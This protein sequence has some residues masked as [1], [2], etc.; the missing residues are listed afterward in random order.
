MD[1]KKFLPGK[2]EKDDLEYYWVLIIEPGWVNAGIWRIKEGGAQV[3]FTGHQFSWGLD[4]ELINATDS[5]LSSAVQ[6]F[7][8][9]LKEPEKTVFAVNSS[10]VSGGQIKEEYLEKIKRLCSDL[11]LKPV[12]F[13]ILPEAIAHYLKSEED[14]SLNAILLG[15]Y[16]ESLEVTLFNLGKLVGTTI[17]AR[18]VSIADDVTEG[19]VRFSETKSLPS[20]FIV[21]DGREKEL[22]EVRQL[23]IS[24]NWDEFTK[25]KFFHTPKVEIIDASIKISAVSLAGAAEIAGVKTLDKSGKVRVKEEKRETDDVVKEEMAEKL[26]FAV[27]ESN[28]GKEVKE[29]ERKEV[30]SAAQEGWPV[31]NIGAVG[32]GKEKK[33]LPL[34]ILFPTLVEKCK[35]L[36]V[37]LSKFRLG[38]QSVSM[39]RKVFIFGLGFLLIFLTLGFVLWW[40][41]PKASVTIYISPKTLEERLSLTLDPD[42][43]ASDISARVLKTKVL[44]TKISSEKTKATTGTKTV[45]EK[46]KGE[47]SVYRVGSE[48]KIA[49]GTLIHGPENLK[50]VLDEELNLASGSAGS[51]SVSKGKVTAQDIGS[52]YNLAT[53]G[54]FKV[55]DYSLADLEAKNEFSFSGGSSREI[56]AV[57]RE[58]Q[59]DLEKDLEEEILAKAKEELRQKLEGSELLVE[60]SLSATASYQL[61]SHKVGD[62]SESLKLSL[63]LDTSTFSVVKEELVNLSEN[64]LK[65][66]IPEGFVL[67]SEQVEFELEREDEESLSFETLVR[68]NLL[69]KVDIEGIA[70]KIRGKYPSLAREYLIKEIPGVVRVEI[71]M[72][73][74]LPGRLNTLPRIAKNIEVE[75]AAEK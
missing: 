67:R 55:G 16:Q 74:S 64:I 19:L 39:G 3:V 62:E 27:G 57:S 65:E 70:K 47:A 13:V 5:A 63:I 49:S 43:S 75:I 23:L 41:Y 42:I 18:S 35:E 32:V 34:N 10:W 61:F 66:K 22:E 17:V 14:V 37:F 9:D 69:P 7:P 15:I 59:E 31:E 56:S 44:E 50:F 71:R 36:L 60:D 53:G 1:I 12:G 20:R 4:E 25:I 54:S 26:G 68:A 72:K 45:G 48:L 73:P 40:Y 24:V 30:I 2:D 21:Y 52:Q 11:S 6:S 29:E 38:G 51:P 58:D 33:G 8:G 28:I 46:A